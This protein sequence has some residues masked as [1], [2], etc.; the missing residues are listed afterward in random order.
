MSASG[1]FLK[2]REAN[3]SQF[4][5]LDYAT[6]QFFRCNDGVNWQFV[7]KAKYVDVIPADFLSTDRGV[8]ES[9]VPNAKNPCSISGLPILSNSNIDFPSKE[10]Y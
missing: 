4:F 2:W 6:Q 9:Q 3:S 1:Q 8:T 10:K 5:R 7:A